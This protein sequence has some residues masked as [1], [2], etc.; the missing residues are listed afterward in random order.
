MKKLLC[1]VLGV[2]AVVSCARKQ[3]TQTYT[4][5]ATTAPSVAYYSDW[6]NAIR[7]DVDMQNM[8]ANTP[9][10]IE[11]PIDMY[12]AMALALK[13]NYSGRVVRYQESLLKAGKTAYAKLPEI[14]SNAGYIN[15][16]YNDVSPDLKVAWNLLDISTLYYMNTDPVFKKNV[17]VEE[18]RKVIQN[19]LQEARVLY[20]KALTAQ[21]LLPVVDQTIEHITLAVD[22]LNVKAKELSAKNESLSTE[23]LVKKRNYMDAI[24]KLSDLKREMETAPEKLASLMGL[25]PSTEYKLVGENYGHFALPEIKSGLP[26]LEWLALTNRPELKAHDLLAANENLDIII[27]NFRNDN[28]EKY[29]S[30][31]NKYNKQWCN[32]AKQATMVVYERAH[33]TDEATLDTLRRQ[34]MTSLILNQVYVGWARY[35]SAVE[36]YQIAMELAGTSENIAENITVKNGSKAEVSQLE[37]ARAIEDEVKASLAYVDLQDALGTMYVTIGLDAVPY[38]LLDSSPSQIALALRANLEKWRQGEFVP[39]DR[40]YLMNIFDKNPPVNF[41]S[42]LMPDYTFETGQHIYITVPQE[43]FEKMG[44]K[45]KEFTTKAGLVD[46]SSLP[47]WLDYKDLTKSFT[48]MAMP[49]DEGTYKIKVYALDDKNNLAYVNFNLNIID[50]YVP[51]LKVKGLNK[52]R[53][54]VV[55]KRCSGNQCKDETLDKTEAVA[56]PIK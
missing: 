31:P 5:S 21:R 6:D 33:A 36:D 27:S 40:P 25:H 4:A 55:L 45:D 19:I 46:D 38:Y 44:W 49:G 47:K 14:A 18:K 16:N 13:Y 56:A 52:T 29:M 10:K 43:V 39:G 2:F 9:R 28:G 41:S 8:Y 22:E 7:Y 20:W 12:M 54:A 35:V 23:E 53:S 50:T 34:R 17:S 1:F 51:S 3:A 26:K 11:K 24:K 32:Q 42:N 37:A 48:G 15:N 30:D